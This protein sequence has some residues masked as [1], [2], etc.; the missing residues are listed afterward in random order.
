MGGQ[1]LNFPQTHSW[2]LVCERVSWYE[3][4]R[5]HWTF[6]QQMDDGLKSFDRSTF[7]MLTFGEPFSELA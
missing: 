5:E 3:C 7:E 1:P 6:A 2:W 4:E